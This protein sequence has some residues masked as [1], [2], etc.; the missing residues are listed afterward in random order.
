MTDT[1]VVLCTCAK[2]EEAL[3]I[4][5]ALVGERL[6]ACVNVL[7]GIQSIYRWQD[8]VE[9]AKEILLIAKTTRER[10]V[11]MTN[12]ITELHTY[13]TPEVIA[14]PVVEGSDRYLSWLHQQ[15]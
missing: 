12:R 15:V 5:N 9:T 4:A 10:F 14:I 6:A 7:P 2:E 1:V 13:E 3:R 8:N 11:G